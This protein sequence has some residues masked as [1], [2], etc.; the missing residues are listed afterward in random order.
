MPF[1]EKNDDAQ[2]ANVA[3]MRQ[4]LSRFETEQGRLGGLSYV[5]LRQD[6]VVI[7]TTPKAGTTWTQQVR[8]FC[9]ESSSSCCGVLGMYTKKSLQFH[10]DC[11][12]N[13]E[14]ICFIL[15]YLTVFFAIKK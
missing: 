6:E 3:L 5:P 12:C 9:M 11:S 13:N 1:E 2:D 4:R 7:T 10:P 14:S 8:P 15:F